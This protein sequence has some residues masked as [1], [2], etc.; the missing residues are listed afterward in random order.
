MIKKIIMLMVLC[1]L[2]SSSDYERL[3]EHKKQYKNSANTQAQKLTSMMSEMNL[4]EI[5][6]YDINNM[7]TELLNKK[8]NLTLWLAIADGICIYRYSG[9]EQINSI[10]YKLK[11][12]ILNLKS[13]KIYKKYDFMNY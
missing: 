13:V 6:Y 7:Q 8:Y 9:K 10:I 5:K 4:V 3:I 11:K 2:A 12:D 1:I